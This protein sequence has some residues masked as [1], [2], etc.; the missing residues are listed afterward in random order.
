MTGPAVQPRDETPRRWTID[1]WEGDLV[2]VEDEGGRILDLP[3]WL[4]PAG[5]REGDVVVVA[6]EPAENG[7][8]RLT[9]RLDH[10]AAAA[11]RAAA[12]SVLAR[13]RARDPGGD[14]DL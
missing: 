2:V 4:L 7:E 1:R 3:A 9:L 14:I 6:A 5:A 13:L 11:A 12:E 10:R 8:R